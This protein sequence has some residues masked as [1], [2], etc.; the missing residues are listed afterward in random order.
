MRVL[1]LTTFHERCGIA[2]YSEA[3]VA[4]LEACGIHV[5]VLSPT[6]QKGDAGWGEQPK[7]LWRRNRAFGLAALPTMRAVRERAPDLVHLQVNRSLYSSRF[8]LAFAWLCRRRGIPLV[9]TLHGRKVGSFGEDLKLLRLLVALRGADL[10]VH[11]ESH[12]AELARERVHVIPHGVDSLP[13]HD[14]AEARRRLGIPEDADVVSHFGFLV[15][16]KGVDEVLAAVAQL[17]KASFPTLSYRVN[18]AIYTTR[19]SRRHFAALAATVKR[20]DLTGAVTMTGEFLSDEALRLELG[21]ASLVVLNYRTGNSQ[22]ASGAVRRALASGRPVAVTGAPV[23]DDVR[24]AVHTMSGSVEDEL[25]RLLG[26][27]ALLEQTA[28]KGRAFAAANAWPEIARR[29]AVLYE[30]VSSRTTAP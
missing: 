16:D 24:G 22:G 6:R 14:R 18:G 17:R 30:K 1:M 9:A 19:E 29:H 12:A 2:T 5:S 8:M 20:L 27:P 28:A 7:R 25:R 15:P 26:S 21:A 23:F 13:T 4:A 11:T 3:L 10:I